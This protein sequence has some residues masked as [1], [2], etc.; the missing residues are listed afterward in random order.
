MASRFFEPPDSASTSTR[1]S[2]NPARPSACATRPGRSSSST[3]YA[4]QPQGRHGDRQPQTRRPFGFGHVRPVPLPAAALGDLKTLLNPRAQPIA[5]GR[6]GLRRQIGQDQPWI[7]VARLPARQQGTVELAVAA[8]EGHARPLPRGA[9]LRHQRLEGNPAHLALGTEG[10]TRVDAKKG[11]PS[12]TGNAPKQTE[13]VQ[14]TIGQHEDRPRPWD[15]PVHLTQHAQ[16]LP[17]PGMFGGG[18]QDD[19]DDWDGTAAIDHAE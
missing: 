3:P 7:L 14:A 13:S 18:G 8:F 4:Q 5:T 10:T 1:A 19:P 2:V 6:T 17:P 11:V 16:P 15:R 9:W 12:Q